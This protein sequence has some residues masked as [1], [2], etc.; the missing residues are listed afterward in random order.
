MITVMAV[1]IQVWVGAGV[2]VTA[3]AGLGVYYAIVGLDKADKVASVVGGLVAVVGLAVAVYAL[4]TSPGGGRRVSQ[5]AK[6]SGRGR[7]IQVGGSQNAAGGPAGN[8]PG[9]GHVVQHG[10]VSDDGAV[11]QV[12]G[13]QNPPDQR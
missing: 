7:V 3:V 4:T 5:R 8:D 2:T 13:D 10:T 6:A 9:H 11:T 12:G 1:R